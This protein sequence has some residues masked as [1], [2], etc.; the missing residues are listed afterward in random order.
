MGKDSNDSVSRQ[1]NLSTLVRMRRETSCRTCAFSSTELSATTPQQRLHSRAA[2]RIRSARAAARARRRGA[3][4]RPRA[5]RTAR[6]A[7]AARLPPRGA[8]RGFFLPGG[9][10]S[11]SA[12]RVARFASFFRAA[13]PRGP[14]FLVPSRW[15]LVPPRALR[16]RKALRVVP[17]RRAKAPALAAGTR[18]RSHRR[19]RLVSPERALHRRRRRRLAPLPLLRVRQLRRPLHAR[20]RLARRLGRARVRRLG[21]G[22]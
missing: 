9:G 8:A 6:A 1:P 20:R 22:E 7:R 3:A 2:P 19:A 5:E 11:G 16:R 12:A 10:S 14:G 13:V 4:A 18:R 17:R 15:F 21:L